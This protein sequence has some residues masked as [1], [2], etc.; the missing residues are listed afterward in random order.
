MANLIWFRKDLRI[1]DNQA[2][3]AACQQKNNGVVGLFILTP[4]TWRSHHMAGCQVDF[5]LQNLKQLK[6]SLATLNIPLL[7]AQLD[8][9]AEIPTYLLKLIQQHNIANVYFNKQYELD[10][11]NRDKKV[12]EQLIENGY[13]VYQYDDQV[14]VPPTTLF[15]QKGTPFTV[16]TPYKKAWL[17]FLEKHPENYHILAVPKPQTVIN[18]SSSEIP[19]KISGFSHQQDISWCLPGEKAALKQ[20]ENFIE[21]QVDHY[22]EQR[23]FPGI[24]GTSRL[25]PY[26]ALGVLSPRQCVATILQGMKYFFTDSYSQ[27]KL[28]FLQELIW[29]DFYKQV[30]F[31]F[32]RVC[33]YQAFKLNTD[34]L[35]AWKQGKTGFPFVDAAMRQLNQ[36][37]WMHNRMRMVVAMFLSKNLL[38]DWRLGERYF[39]ENLLDGDLS[40]NNGGWQ[41]S[42]STGT[43]AVP[44]FRIFNP[45][46]QSKRF[47]P[48]GKYIRYYC[49]ELKGLDNKSIHDPEG[50]GVRPASYPK[51]II[52]YKKSRERVLAAFKSL[53]K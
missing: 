27:G 40:A 47:D 51:P 7:I 37:G 50:F 4:E 34:H 2:L 17:N 31:H 3:S 12:T 21:N 23:D 18:V 43:D 33:R 38:L 53:K 8:A 35:E 22:H 44:Y 52:D 11:L 48:E 32:P 49:P 5:L 20:L 14:I 30:M 10:E 39:M 46:E 1:H 36:T 19:E 15:S 9:F 45:T 41:W 13:K 25:S 24:D 29:R 28:I 16:Y 26:L 42:A 6:D